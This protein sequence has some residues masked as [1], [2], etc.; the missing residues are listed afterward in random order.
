MSWPRP[1]EILGHSG[2]Q[3]VAPLDAV[4]VEVVVLD[5][6]RE[7]GFLGILGGEGANDAVVGDALVDEAKDAAPVAHVLAALDAGTALVPAVV[8]DEERGEDDAG[9][10]RSEFPVEVEKVDEDADGGEEV[11]EKRDAGAGDEIVDGGGVVDDARDDTAGLAFLVEFQRELLQVRKDADA[12]VAGDAHAG[13][14]DE[15]IP[16]HEGK[17]TDDEERDVDDEDGDDLVPAV[18]R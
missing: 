6:A 2:E 10:A 4:V 3:S 12:K 5:A 15:V 7:A 14:L 1:G 18:R 13:G 11:G 17:R 8:D 16:Q 9:D